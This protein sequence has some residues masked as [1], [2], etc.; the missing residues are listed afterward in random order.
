VKK[1]VGKIKSLVF[2]EVTPGIFIH[3]AQKVGK[4]ERMND[5]KSF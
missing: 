5:R 2:T 3:F 1:T 4:K